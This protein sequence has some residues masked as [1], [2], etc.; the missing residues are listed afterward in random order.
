MNKPRVA[1]YDEIYSQIASLYENVC[2]IPKA[3]IELNINKRN[4]YRICKKLGKPSAAAKQNDTAL[5]HG[6]NIERKASPLP[7]H[8]PGRSDKVIIPAKG[9]TDH[10]GRPSLGYM[11]ELKNKL[12]TQGSGLAG[13]N[14]MNSHIINEQSENADTGIVE[15]K[16]SVN[17]TD[18]E[19]EYKYYE[20]KY[21]G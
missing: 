16:T 2:S 12:K 19:R 20:Q 14:N 3:C 15:R 8:T 7:D 4:Y 1:K 18:Y 10:M 9:N 11:E 21:L 17:E 13:Q 6:G 5:Q